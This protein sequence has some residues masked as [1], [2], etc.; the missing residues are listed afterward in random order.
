MILCSNEH[1]ALPQ[2]ISKW[3]AEN[4]EMAHKLAVIASKAQKAAQLFD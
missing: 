4:T 3:F 2:E 1:G